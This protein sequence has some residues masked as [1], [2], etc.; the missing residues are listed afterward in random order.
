VDIEI[1]YKSCKSK[2]EAFEKTKEVVTSEIVSTK[3]GVTAKLI[4]DFDS[5]SAQ[6]TGKG[7]TI[8]FN[9]LENSLTGKIKLSLLLKP[10]RGKI[11]KVLN[12]QLES[13]L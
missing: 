5:M 11:I 1:S 10:L 2:E 9:F 3:F 6:A 13:I 12:R 4:Y 8:D 7:F